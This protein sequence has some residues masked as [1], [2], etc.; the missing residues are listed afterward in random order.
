MKVYCSKTWKANIAWSCTLYRA[1]MYC[2]EIHIS[3]AQWCHVDMSIAETAACRM[4]HMLD[5]KR[6]VE[7]CMELSLALS[8]FRLLWWLISMLWFLASAGR[9]I[10]N[11]TLTHRDIWTR[12][13]SNICSLIAGGVWGSFTHK[14]LSHTVGDQLHEDSCMK[15]HFSGGNPPSHPRLLELQH[16]I[17][18]P[19]QHGV[20]IHF[21]IW[22]EGIRN[23]H[24]A[25]HQALGFYSNFRILAYS[26]SD[27]KN[28][29]LL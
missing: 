28:D 27:N 21:P 12:G 25:S 19:L 6:C 23:E 16:I 29:W 18:P 8:F 2:L 3:K 17:G 15:V 20:V 24:W 1:G 10:Q 11:P 5:G 22:Y 9:V 7:G 4:L 14:G 26:I 13:Y